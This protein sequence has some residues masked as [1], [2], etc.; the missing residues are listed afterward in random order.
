MT[1]LISNFGLTK[2]TLIHAKVTAYN[3][4][5]A[6][7]ESDENTSGVLIKTEPI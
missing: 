4:N 7:I 5:G 2:A 1:Y 6:S 3:I